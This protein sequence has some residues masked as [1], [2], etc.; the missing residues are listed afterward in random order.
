MNSCPSSKPLPQH[1]PFTL[2]WKSKIFPV[3]SRPH[4]Y[5][6][7][8]Y[9][10]ALTYSSPGTLTIFLLFG[11]L[12]LLSSFLLQGLWTDCF[13]PPGIFPYS[14]L[15]GFLS[16]YSCLF[17]RLEGLLWSS[18]NVCVLFLHQFS[19]WPLLSHRTLLRGPLF[20]D[21][22]HIPLI[23]NFHEGREPDYIV[24]YVIC[25]TWQSRY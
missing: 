24:S 19:S 15:L 16:F 2:N 10:S 21:F 6:L 8:S 20:M 11:C 13:S 9:C 4:R 7:L 3:T 1:L 22:E 17:P 5:T 18:I 14:S 23:C 12:G 25:K